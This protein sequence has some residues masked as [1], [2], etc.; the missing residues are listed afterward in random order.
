[1]LGSSPNR[2]ALS[3]GDRSRIFQDMRTLPALLTFVRVTDD[4]CATA[5]VFPGLNIRRGSVQPERAGRRRARRHARPATGGRD[6][7]GVEFEPAQQRPD[8]L[9]IVDPEPRA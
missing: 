1:M 3:S 7:S 5:V 2:M 9:M 6:R 4:T 8:R